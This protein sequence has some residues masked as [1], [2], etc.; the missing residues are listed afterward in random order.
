MSGYLPTRHLG[1]IGWG[2]LRHD[3]SGLSVGVLALYAAAF[4]VVALLGIRRQ[5]EQ[6][7]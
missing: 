7:T 3:L 6:E 4:G 5:V 1:E 2:V